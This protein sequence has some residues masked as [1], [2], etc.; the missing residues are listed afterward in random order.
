MVNQIEFER[1]LTFRSLLTFIFLSLSSVFNK[2]WMEK[3]NVKRAAEAEAEKIVKDKAIE[4]RTGWAAQRDIR[5]SA[6]KVR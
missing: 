5:L 1:E 4:E 3:L 6:R 2:A